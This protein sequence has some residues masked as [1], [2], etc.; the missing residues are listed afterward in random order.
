ML[1]LYERIFYS[2]NVAKLYTA[3]AMINYML[4]FET[5]LAAA[6][7]KQGIVPDAAAVIDQCCRVE[8]INK[9]QLINDAALEGKWPFRS[10]NS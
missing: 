4:R 2:E 10:S 6:Q 3:E 5:A 9:E 7:A 8:Y 1:Q